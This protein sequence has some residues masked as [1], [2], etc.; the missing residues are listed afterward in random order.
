M[1][2]SLNLIAISVFLMTLSVLLGPLIHLSPVVPAIAT[3]SVLGLATLDTFSWQGQGSTL[4]LDWL[5]SFSPEHRARVL[6]HEAGHFLVA[7]QLGIP[8]TGYALNA[9]EALRQGYPGNGGVRFGDPEL[10]S[11]LQQGRLSV[12]R[13]DRYCAVWM[14]G[15]AAEDLAYGN[16]EGGRGDRQQLLTIL[17]QLGLSANQCQQKERLA[18]LQAKTILQENQSAFESLLP[19]MEERAPVEDCIRALEQPEKSIL[20]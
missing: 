18:L 6:R 5:A 4:L 14:A 17:F 20:S 3:A 2:L 12:Q 11:E 1:N 13:L 16:V 8:I 10:E 19:L 7:H 15:I 9:W